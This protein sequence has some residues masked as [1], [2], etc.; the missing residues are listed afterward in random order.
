VK[1]FD[2]DPQQRNKKIQSSLLSWANNNLRSFPWRTSSSAYQI[3][4]AELLLKRTT[5]KA[6]S[7]VY[8][9][10]L[11]RYPTLESLSQAKEEEL[12]SIL[13]PI[14]YNKL[15]SK[16]LKAIGTFIV[17]NY[18]GKI[19]S[20]FSELMKIPFIGPYTAGA[21]MCFGF[22]FCAPMVDSNVERIISRVFTNSF[23]NKP[24]NKE[25]IK[26][27]SGI[28]P[29]DRYREFNLALLDLGALICTPQNPKCKQCPLQ[30]VCDYVTTNQRV[31]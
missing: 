6:A 22:N 11:K 26:V 5:A 15:R 27:I 10:F 14:G 1:G 2:K 30:S 23:S 9:A 13:K 3:V 4:I 28:I 25:V 24:S 21:I 8:E 7:R 29:T 31:T 16:E 12:E 17:N 18:G 20:D 19:P